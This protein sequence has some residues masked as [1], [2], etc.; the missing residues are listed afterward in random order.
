MPTFNNKITSEFYF[1][2]KIEKVFCTDE[3]IVCPKLYFERDYGV[4]DLPY[5]MFA[6]PAEWLEKQETVFNKA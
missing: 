5:C 6:V 2:Y 1:E 4:A 3:S